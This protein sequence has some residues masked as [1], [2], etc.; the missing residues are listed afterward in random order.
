MN[1][2]AESIYEN[3]CRSR[4]PLGMLPPEY[5]LPREEKPS[6]ENKVRFADGAMD[7]IAI[8]HMGVP[9][10][11]TALLEQALQA[12][13]TDPQ[14]AHRLVRQWAKDGHM[15]SAAGKI[16]KYVVSHQQELSPNPVYRLAVECALKGTRRE[17]VKFGLA[18]LPLFETDHDEQLK[19]ALRILALSDEF[20]LYVLPIAGRWTLSAQEVLRIAKNVRGWGR[21]HAVVQLEP[22]TE[23]IADWLFAEGWNN[24]VLPAYS[25]LECYRKSGMRKRLEGTMTDRDYTCACRLLQALLVEGP[26]SGISETEDAEGLLD[27]FL[28]CSASKAVSPDRQKALELVAEYAKKQ[29]MNRIAE[30]TAALL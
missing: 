19:N 25:A 2:T 13:V 1:T 21:I 3:I 29:E 7:G 11:D 9:S 12:A 27:A 18:L 14:E 20:T 6:S 26:V 16:Q 10:Q 8:Y 28:T 4:D 23:E 24:T 5:S 30:R 17:E 15:V 22:E